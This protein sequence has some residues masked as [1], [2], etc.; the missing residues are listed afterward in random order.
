MLTLILGHSLGH[1]HRYSDLD[2]QVQ[3]TA[4]A[5]GKG[6]RLRCARRVSIH[7]P[8]AWSSAV[9]FKVHASVLGNEMV[10]ARACFIWRQS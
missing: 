4:L 5:E 6:G 2:T 3:N 10:S 1:R 9:R 8:T 7:S